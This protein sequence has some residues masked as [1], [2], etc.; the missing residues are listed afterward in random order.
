M[1]A[2]V[3]WRLALFP[4]SCAI[5]CQ[6]RQ[7]RCGGTS[8]EAA[9]IHS[10]RFG[11]GLGRLPCGSEI[12]ELLGISLRIS[13]DP[14]VL[15]GPQAPTC[16]SSGEAEFFGTVTRADKYGSIGRRFWYHGREEIL[17]CL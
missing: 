11:Q 1:T 6:K 4:A 3:E 14:D 10:W 17:D 9:G 12:H 13:F 15:H 2:P 5:Y 7:G 8:S 16:F